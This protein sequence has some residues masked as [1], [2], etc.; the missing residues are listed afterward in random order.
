ME[1]GGTGPATRIEDDSFQLLAVGAA[2]SGVGRHDHFSALR[3]VM[4]VLECEGINSGS[5]GVRVIPR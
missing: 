4:L 5:V 3:D 2:C 1:V